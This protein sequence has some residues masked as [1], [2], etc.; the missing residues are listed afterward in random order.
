MAEKRRDLKGR[1]LKDGESQRSNG[2]YQYRYTDI[3]GKRQYIYAGTLEE[4][5]DREAL[6][7]KAFNDGLD[8]LAGEITLLELV[9]KILTQKQGMRYNTRVNYDFVLNILEKEDFCLWKIN[10][11]KTS[12]A[13]SRRTNAGAGIMMW[14]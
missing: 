3:R 2:S 13:K 9:K 8:Y 7:E 6:I 4:L 11:I 1:V 14:S 10:T 5:R 12:D